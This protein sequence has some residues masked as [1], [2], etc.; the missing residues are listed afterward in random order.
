MCEI[1]SI[2]FVIKIIPALTKLGRNRA[3]H[4]NGITNIVVR[5][6][7][8]IVI[9]IRMTSSCTCGCNIVLGSSQKLQRRLAHSQSQD[10]IIITPIQHGINMHANDCHNYCVCLIHFLTKIKIIVE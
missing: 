6:D 10:N 4:T 8:G 7:V 3:I 9:V 1:S 2:L 5:N